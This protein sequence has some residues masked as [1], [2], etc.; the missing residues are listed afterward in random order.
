MLL[1]KLNDYIKTIIGWHMKRY[2]AKRIV[3]S[4]I[5]EY[6]DCNN[7]DISLV[8]LKMHYMNYI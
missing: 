5:D 6:N 1:L 7:R 2:L 4:L 8:G 3:V